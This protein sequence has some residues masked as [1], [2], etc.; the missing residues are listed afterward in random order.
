MKLKNLFI[1]ALMTVIAAPAMAQAP[2][3]DEVQKQAAAL[4]KAGNADGL[5]DLEKVN[6]KN[7]TGLVSIAK[8]YLAAG[9]VAN[10][11]ATAQKAYTFVNENKKA[12]AQEKCITYITL[13]N[14]ASAKDEAGNAVSWYQSAMY[15]DP[16][17]PDG[18]RL[19][20]TATSKSDPNGA[21]AAIEQVR[22]NR[23]DYPVDLIAADIANGAGKPAKAIE[24]YS[25]VKLSDMQPYQLGAYA[26]NLYLTQKIEK[27]VEVAEYGLTVAPRSA[28]LNRLAFWGN[29]DLKKW[30][31]ALAYA[32]KLFYES[33]SVKISSDDY[34]RKINALRG[35]ER[36]D[37]ALAE[38]SKLANDPK[39]PKADQLFAL[40]Q[41]AQTYSD[42][43]DYANAI[44]AYEKYL[45]A[46][47]D[48]ASATDIA[49]LGQQYM[50]YAQ[51]NPAK[52]AE[53][54]MKADE[55]FAKMAQNPDPA[56]A[57]YAIYKRAQV[58]NQMD[59]GK[60][61][62]KPFYDKLI[63]T[64]NC[65]VARL[66]EAYLYNIS[67]FGNI[68]NDISGA[69]PYAEKLAEIDPENPVAKQVLS[70]KE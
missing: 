55:V 60:G 18:Y 31:A 48:K 69:M 12:T 11:E 4:I 36:Y 70:L 64:P 3:I 2:A 66:K 15:A 38:L 33:D 13:G 35:A 62:A 68:K 65:N 9:D 10:A 8:A 20:A 6:K 59:G 54:L 46:A 28:T 57:E 25:K 19:Y 26:T 53:S 7:P 56:T 52:K 34:G 37:E 5:K 43:E 17:N 27:A 24:Y 23:P 49:G 42:K 45:A 44:P 1:G 21:L 40:K 51:Q 39:M 47:G 16:Q 63:E 22:Q 50:Y 29:T 30:D 41:I 61:L 32:D 14:I 67:Y 58:A